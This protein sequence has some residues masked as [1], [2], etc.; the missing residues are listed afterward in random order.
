MT[1]SVFTRD[2]ISHFDLFDL[3]D[4]HVE[5]AIFK[6]KNASMKATPLI[7]KYASSVR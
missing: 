5:Q 2:K 4:K 7:F 1:R 3:F 6:I